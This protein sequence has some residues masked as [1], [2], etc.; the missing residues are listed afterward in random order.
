MVGLFYVKVFVY[1][2]NILFVGVNYIE[3]YLSVNYIEYK[4]LKFF[5]IILIVFGGYIYLVEVKDYGKYE[6]LGKIRD[7]VFGEV[8]DK[9]LRVMNLG[10]LGGFIIDNLVK[11]GNKYVIEFLRVYLEE[12][13]YDFSFSGL[14]FFVLNYLN[15]KRMKNEEI[16]VE[17]VVVFF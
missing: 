16:V 9:I 17:D 1:I 4:D 14:K 15:G 10:Y 11:N 5:F 3:G 7:D 12:D 8:F 6:I 13:S 2:L